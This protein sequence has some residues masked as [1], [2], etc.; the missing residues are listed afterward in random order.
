MT[1]VTSPGDLVHPFTVSDLGEMPD[2]GRR[3]ELIDAALLVSPAPGSAAS[4][5]G[6]LTDLVRG[7]RP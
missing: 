5:G 4:R 6:D 1:V 3:Y 7:L 2:D